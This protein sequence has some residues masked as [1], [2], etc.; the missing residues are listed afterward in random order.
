MY[1]M[2]II[3]D[4]LRYLNLLHTVVEEQ[5]R[6]LHVHCGTVMCFGVSSI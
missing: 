6:G 3:E 5:K 2:T 1:Y 4:F